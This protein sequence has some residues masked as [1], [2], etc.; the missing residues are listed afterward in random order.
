MRISLTW[1][2]HPLSSAGCCSY[3]GLQ[4]HSSLPRWVLGQ[5]SR[6]LQ[7]LLLPCVINIARSTNGLPYL[8][9]HRVQLGIP[10]EIWKFWCNNDMFT[11]FQQISAENIHIK[12]LTFLSPLIVK[13]YFDLGICFKEDNSVMLTCA[14]MTSALQPAILTPA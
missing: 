13:N 6:Q 7:S 12:I 8:Y 1:F 11:T 10:T 14:G 5:G 2:L 3:S 4:L 9:P